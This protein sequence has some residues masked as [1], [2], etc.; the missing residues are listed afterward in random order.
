MTKHI[1]NYMVKVSTPH[2]YWAAHIHSRLFLEVSSYSSHTNITR[3]KGGGAKTLNTFE[4]KMDHSALADSDNL[5]YEI[6]EYFE[7]IAP[8]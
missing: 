3:W 4:G 7:S 5:K 2:C 8:L 1:V 6:V